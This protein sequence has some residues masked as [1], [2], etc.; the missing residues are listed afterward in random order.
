MQFQDCWIFS[1]GFVINRAQQIN[2]FF[3]FQ[4]F[5]YLLQDQLA[6]YLENSKGLEN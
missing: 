4:S 3:Y 1:E 2:I 6:T 5:R